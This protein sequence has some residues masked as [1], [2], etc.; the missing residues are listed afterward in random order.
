[1]VQGEVRHYGFSDPP[2][3]LRA[4]HPKKTKAPYWYIQP[5]IDRYRQIYKK[6][7]GIAFTSTW[8][9][10]IRYKLIEKLD[11]VVEKTSRAGDTI[12]AVP[13]IFSA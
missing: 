1:M 13:F 2:I 3:D 4:L 7:W 8:W 10:D 11:M 6:A 12:S 5:Q 9:K